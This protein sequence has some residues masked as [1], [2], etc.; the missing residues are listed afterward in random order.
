MR[1]ATGEA[2]GL[3]SK[4]NCVWE[5]DKK[6]KTG[7]GQHKWDRKW[8][9][10]KKKTQLVM[11]RKRKIFI[12]SRFWQNWTTKRGQVS[13]SDGWFH[14]LLTK[15][16]FKIWKSNLIDSSVR[17]V[18]ECVCLL[19]YCGQQ[20]GW[21]RALL[22]FWPCNKLGVVRQSNFFRSAVTLQIY[23]VCVW[24]FPLHNTAM[25]NY[26]HTCGCILACAKNLSYSATLAP[27]IFFYIFFKYR[28][29][30]PPILTFSQTLSNCLDPVCGFYM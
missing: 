22:G 29:F 2:K 18:Y 11:V 1:N 21:V 24:D 20:I 25:S 12:Q 16:R 6:R 27:T 7:E 15:L 5:R 26:V 19:L 4:T 13:V 9:R 23:L 17:R 10:V 8:V 14:W 28:F 30:F 3:E